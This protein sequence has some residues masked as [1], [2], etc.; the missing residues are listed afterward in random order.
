MKKDTHYIELKNGITLPYVDKGDPSGT[1]VVF[2]HGVTDSHNSFDLILEH[3][4]HEIRA[5]AVTQRGHGD[6]SKPES[7][8]GPAELANDLKL[9]LAAMKIDSAFIVGHSM[10]S[11][12]AQR[13]AAENHEQ[14]SGLVLIGSFATCADNDGIKEFVEAVVKPLNDPI[15]V[16]IAA[17]FQSG[18]YSKRL[19][20]W[21]EELV[22]SE[23]L[24]APARVWK[25][26]CMSMIETDHSTLLAN[27]TAKT[28]L[29]WGSQDA[30]FSVNEQERLLSL[31]PDARLKIYDG[32][33]HAPHWEDPK[34]AG[35][36]ILSLVKEITAESRPAVLI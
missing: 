13:F 14:V 24:K 29:L 25:E 9:F 6:A 8:Y 34:R 32:V 16:E 4:P 27:I 15:P 12:A 11:F 2:L 1:P 18:T 30:F 31:I 21:F 23:C 19:P 3:I 26:A 36:D 5:I 17:G 20:G 10:G 33:G 22:V 7:G 28:L 35:E